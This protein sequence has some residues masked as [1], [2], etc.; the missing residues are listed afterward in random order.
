MNELE[1]DLIRV[2]KLIQVKN[3][4]R[5][6][7]LKSLTTTPISFNARFSQF[8]EI[9]ISLI[10]EDFIFLLFYRHKLPKRHGHSVLVMDVNKKH[11]SNG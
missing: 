6:I 5:T 4:I 9:L 1:Y 7:I 11:M 3:F 8:P 2:S 10:L